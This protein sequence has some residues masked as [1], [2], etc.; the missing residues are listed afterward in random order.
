[1]VV[2]TNNTIDFSMD[3]D[4]KD[5]IETI[6]QFL[7]FV[8]NKFI[9][10]MVGFIAGAIT[11][12]AVVIASLYI[13]GFTLD[14]IRMGSIAACWMSGFG[15]YVPVGSPISIMQSIGTLGLKL[16]ANKISV[17]IGGI[18]GAYIA[19]RIYS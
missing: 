1:M 3:I 16:F 2:I 19:F 13:L 9:V 17:A 11:L 18:I 8:A 10:V 15:G 4:L 5:T 7:V 6:K 14:G 12:P